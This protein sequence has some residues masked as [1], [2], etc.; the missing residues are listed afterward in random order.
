M[1]QKSQGRKPPAAPQPKQQPPTAGHTATRP[2]P[3]APTRRD[4]AS[5]TRHA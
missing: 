4:K 1:Q 5:L 2:H 3:G